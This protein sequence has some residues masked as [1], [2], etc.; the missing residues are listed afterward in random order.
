MWWKGCSRA[1]SL[2]ALLLALALARAA[3]GDPLPALQYLS[4]SPAATGI[5]P[6]T[7]ILVRPGGSVDPSSSLI[8]A[9]LR[10]EGS[11][12]GFHD[13]RLKLSDDATTLVFRPFAPFLAGETVTC[14]L[15]AGIRTDAAGDVPPATWS[16]TIAGPER[17]RLRGYTPPAEG[18]DDP[19]PPPP[20]ASSSPEAGLGSPASMSDSLP[21]DFP[22]I[23][24]TVSGNPAPGRI[25]LA[26]FAERDLEAPSHLMILEND[27]TPFFQRRLP[28]A[29]LDWKRQPNGWLTYFDRSRRAFYALDSTY[30]VVD[31]FRCGNGYDTDLHELRL[32]PDGHALLMAY[33]PQIVDMSRIVPKGF[34]EATVLGLIIQEIDRE[35]EVVFQWRSWDHFQILDAVGIPFSRATIDYVHGNSLDVGPDGN[36]LLSCRHM[37]EVTKISRVTGDVLWRLGGKNNQ[38]RFIND[39][40]GFS[41]QH[42]ARWLPGGHITV[43]DN[44]NLHSPPFSRAVEY[45]LD[46]EK[47]TAKL[48][49]EYRHDPEVFGFA[50]G[51][52]Q[53][54]PNGDTLI[55]W[56]F[57]TPTMTEV[58]PDR[59]VVMEL[60]FDPDIAT[61]RAFRF[62]WPTMESAVV[63]LSPRTV[64][65]AGRQGW[66][67][68]SI[69]SG[70]FDA[71]E[72]VVASVR[73][74]GIVPADPA[75]ASVG[76]LNA[77]GARDLTLR[78]DGDA[79]ARLLSP[80][81]N[82]V[83]LSGEL[84]DG[85][86][87]HG[88]ALI[89]AVAPQRKGGEAPPLKLVSAPGVLP[90]RLRFDASA[91]LERTFA[92]Y[93][94]RG[95][96][97]RRWR[98]E[99]ASGRGVAWDGRT[100]GVYFIRA[101]EAGSV[102]RALKIVVAR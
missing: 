93:D 85:R 16:F 53:R 24:A 90:V 37:S 20:G 79:V 23:A 69:E 2:A 91:V 25:F 50:A 92:V 77:D 35:K 65:V 36:L 56:G 72:V 17:E 41:Y 42:D 95:R 83:E 38:F 44:G 88:Y 3:A 55:G 58:S 63:D 75:S 49:W 9:L 5:L 57:T 59:R 71:A 52:V 19:S 60:S 6:E 31:S 73:L 14:D 43:F 81:S 4:P 64:N 82:R 48:V 46:E 8:P 47:L 30:T 78:F 76:D 80:G 101:E 15:A 10:V 94:V 66:V 29:G 99:A 18:A 39:P 13:G 7:N 102:G 62:E 98:E 70:E 100:D 27:G 67:T 54:L 12:S 40:I 45:E 22:R 61:Y 1:G 74:L 68:A 89:N 97:V 26:D 32:L 21:D 28:G 11:E 34:P 87:F 33:D 51:S 86:R 96:L 84:D